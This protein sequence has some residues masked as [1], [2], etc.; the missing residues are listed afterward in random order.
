MENLRIFCDK[1]NPE[2]RFMCRIV[3]SKSWCVYKPIL[4][5]VSMVNPGKSPKKIA[6]PEKAKTSNYISGGAIK[7]VC[8]KFESEKPRMDVGKNLCSWVLFNFIV[9]CDNTESSHGF[10]K[11]K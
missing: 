7:T 10:L 2:R 3:S 6:I 4:S 11:C 5:R 9:Y 1:P 8:L